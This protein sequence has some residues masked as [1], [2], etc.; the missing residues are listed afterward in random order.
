MGVLYAYPD[1]THS[2]KPSN[3]R[4]LAIESDVPLNA[5][6]HTGTKDH[7]IVLWGDFVHDS[8]LYYS[9]LYAK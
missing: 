6:L 3:G 5:G 4:L 8:K 1:R 2:V 9:W 7:N